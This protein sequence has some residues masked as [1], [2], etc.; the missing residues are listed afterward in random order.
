VWE[1]VEGGG[2]VRVGQE[3][4]RIHTH[5]RSGHE[6]RRR[7]GRRRE[8]HK[9]AEQ[10]RRGVGGRAEER[11]RRRRS[12]GEEKREEKKRAELRGAIGRRG[13]TC[14]CLRRWRSL[15]CFCTAS[16]EYKILYIYIIIGGAHSMPTKQ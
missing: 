9:G 2:S 12:R 10:R 6:E 11:R 1:G 8:E 7:R 14:F 16:C 3:N 5:A 13:S 4:A 15:W